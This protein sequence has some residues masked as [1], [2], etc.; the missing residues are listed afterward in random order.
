MTA[1]SSQAGDEMRLPERPPVTGYNL[2]KKYKSK[3]F[4]AL[5]RRFYSSTQNL[6]NNIKKNKKKIIVI[7]DQQNIFKL[8]NRFSKKILDNFM[9]VNSI[10]L[11]DY[12]SIICRGQISK[13]Q[14]YT[15]WKKKYK[16]KEQYSNIEKINFWM[17]KRYT[18]FR[19]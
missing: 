15:K 18:T 19:F 6:I 3:S 9:Y 17:I 10:H 16:I 12:V 1:M 5:N 2:A 4:I 8:K 13:I 14:N 7:N 11:L